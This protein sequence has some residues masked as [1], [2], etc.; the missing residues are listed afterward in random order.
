MPVGTAFHERTFA[1]CQSLNYREWSGYY[2]VSVYEVHHEHEYNAIRNACALIDI[3]PLYKYLVTGQDATKLVNRVIT[4]D[5]KKVAVGQVIYCCWCDEQGK[6]I[7][8][9]TITRLE[10]N[11]YRWTAADP[12]LRWFRQNALNMDAQIEDIS[13]R[14]AA[15]A[16]QGPTSGTLLK[17]V[18]EADIANL[19]YFR[20]TSGKIAGVPV[21]ISRTGYTGDLGYEIWVPWSDA[22]KVWDALM[23]KG[24]QF[25]IHAAGMLAL[26]VARV[27]A[28]LLLIEVDY[29]SSKKALI[30][31][32]KYSPYELGFEKMVHLQKENFVGK[33]ALERDHKQGVPRQLV[34]LEIDWNE[35]EARYDKFGLSPAAPSQ[36]SRVP[37]P[38]YLEGK[39]VGKATTTTWSPVLKK[40]IALAS[41]DTAHAKLGTKLQ[42][43][44]TIEAMRQN[45]TA[46]VVKLPFF[47]PARKTAV[48]V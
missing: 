9:G 17:S 16:L 30:S 4:R 1:L 14:T 26:D 36:A 18:A 31:S 11:K 23:D 40:L 35:V 15:L 5:I 13:E 21:D 47:N 8:D 33:A 24:K 45:V 41:V 37:V 34:G 22:V 42:M 43:E 3:T 25:D 6:V 29:S 7:D 20:M 12:S 32:Q 46:Q 39:Q 48:P 10:E 28:G 27:E 38:L 2:T 19:K 44:I